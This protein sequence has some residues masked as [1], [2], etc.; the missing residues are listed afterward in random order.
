MNTAAMFASTD[1][2]IESTIISLSL[3]IVLGATLL[4]IVFV[5]IASRIVGKK[6]YRKYKKPLFMAIVT[7]I[8]APSLVMTGSTIYI[9]TISDSKGPVHW[10]T[11]VEF[12]VCGQEI[13]LRDPYE[14]LS[15]KVGTS[16]YHEH[17]DKRIHLEGVVIDESYD[18]SLEK[19][20][21]V[22]GGK[23]GRD[24]ITIPTM[25]SLFEDDID[26]DTVGGNQ[27]VVKQYAKTDDEGRTVLELE[28]GMQCGSGE[29]GELQAFVYRYNEDDDTY[30]QTKLETPARYV[31]RD[32]PNVPP[33]D[34]LIVEFD[35]SKERTDKLCQ[36]YGV[37][38]EKRCVEFGVKTFNPKVCN[39]KERQTTPFSEGVER[40]MEQEAL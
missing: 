39:I 24:N 10:H 32:E 23:I 6:K 11:D 29:T 36:Q 35:R 34:C 25:P 17:N 14:F 30:T 28:N 22:T 37:R 31:M 2:D 18:A 21:K 16:T 15:N 26:G 9:N 3:R 12:W 19:F 38:D 1:G 40:I 5:L 4:L 7:A 13:E 27:D 33:G 8:I 20:M